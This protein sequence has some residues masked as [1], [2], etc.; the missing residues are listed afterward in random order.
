MEILDTET[1][2]ADGMAGFRAYPN[3]EPQHWIWTHM[4]KLGQ[5]CVHTSKLPPV[6][7]I[8]EV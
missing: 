6:A 4:K 8:A 3:Y 7:K 5:L 2:R 1:L